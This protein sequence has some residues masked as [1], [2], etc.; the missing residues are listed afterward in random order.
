MIKPEDRLR[1]FQIE[2]NISTK[3]PLSLVVQF[4]RMVGGK[5]FPPSEKPQRQDL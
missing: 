3:G 2:N 5:E 4:T 1:A